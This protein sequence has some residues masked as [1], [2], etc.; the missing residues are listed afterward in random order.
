[1]ADGDRGICWKNYFRFVESVLPAQK[2]WL[3]GWLVING[4]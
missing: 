2:N 3:D 4:S 1:M